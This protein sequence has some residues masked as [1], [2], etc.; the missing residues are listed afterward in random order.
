MGAGRFGYIETGWRWI[1]L[2]RREPIN[3]DETSLDGI[4][5][6]SGMVF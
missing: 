2:N 3:M 4:M 5:I 6:S 1:T